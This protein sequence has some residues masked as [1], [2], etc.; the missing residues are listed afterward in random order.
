MAKEKLL[1]PGVVTPGQCVGYSCEG[2]EELHSI[3][4]DCGEKIQLAASINQ[5][6]IYDYLF[7]NHAT[8]PCN[9]P[10]SGQRG[11]KVPRGEGPGGCW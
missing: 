2:T 11:W 6:L 9:V 1:V 7:L 4:L 8:T 10:G 3:P 5:V